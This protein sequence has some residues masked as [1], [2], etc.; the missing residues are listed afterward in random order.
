MQSWRTSDELSYIR[1]LGTHRHVPTGQRG[2]PVRIIPG[3]RL[4]LLRAY[5]DTLDRRVVWGPVNRAV[6]RRALDVAIAREERHRNA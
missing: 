3:D 2:V 6:V 1:G 5:R 4:A